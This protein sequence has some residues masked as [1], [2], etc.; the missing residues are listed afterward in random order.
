MKIRQES[1]KIFE[2]FV[3]AM[4]FRVPPPVATLRQA[5]VADSTEVEG[6]ERC[7]VST[8]WVERVDVTPYAIII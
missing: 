3:T 6:V 2:A 4:V 1:F 7:K 5:A 8:L